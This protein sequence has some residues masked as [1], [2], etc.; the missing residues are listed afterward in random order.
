MPFGMVGR[1]GPGMRQ[2]VRLGDRS[3]GRGN[4]GRKYGAPHRNQWGLCGVAVRKCVNRQ[5]CGLGS[6]PIENCRP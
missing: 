2:V 4:F 5:S 3:T 1:T 6:W